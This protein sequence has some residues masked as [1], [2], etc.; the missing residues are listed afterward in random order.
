MIESAAIR[1]FLNALALPR[2][3]GGMATASASPIPAT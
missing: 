2:A 3:P 1:C